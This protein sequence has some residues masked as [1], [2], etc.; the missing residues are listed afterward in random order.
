AVLAIFTSAVSRALCGEVQKFVPDVRDTNIPRR[1]S[2][3]PG[4]NTVPIKELGLT[5]AMVLLFLAGFFILGVLGTMWTLAIDFGGRTLPGTA[6]GTLNFFNYLGAG[7]Q[8]IL[9]G[10]ILSYTDRDWSLVFA[11]I[12]GLLVIGALLAAV[13]RK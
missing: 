1:S 7:F 9:I 8:G 2:N 12:A 3:R 11:T 6:V 10:G 5:W 4:R 13:V